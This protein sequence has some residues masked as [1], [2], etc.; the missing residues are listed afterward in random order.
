M[1]ALTELWHFR[2]LLIALTIREI[3]IR[4]KQTLLGA[5]WA[6]LQPL[7]MMIIFSV[8]FRLFLKVKTEGIPYPLFYYSGLVP[9]TF[10]STSVSF[11]SLAVVNNSNL[12][13]KIYFPRE[14]LP[15]ASLGAALLD[16]IIAGIIFIGFMIFY[17]VPLTFHLISILPIILTL[18]IFAAALILIA[19]ALNVMW[20]DVKFVI[21]LLIQLWMILSPI[22]YPISQVPERLQSFYVL[23]PLAPIIDNFRR[24]TIQ[25]ASPK[26]DELGL[27]SVL[28]LVSFWAAYIFFKSKEKKFADII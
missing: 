2:E 16:F 27:A 14:V 7:S 25:G 23:N 17:N 9:W 5:A 21:P 4:Y 8:V 19:S 3:K 11:G 24:V 1:K 15:F 18:T 22:I 26:W 28:S 6:V 12:V 10:F 13:T 20:R